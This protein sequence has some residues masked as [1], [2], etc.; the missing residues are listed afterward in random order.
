MKSL[1]HF[2]LSVT[3]AVIVFAGCKKE[4]APPA[5]DAPAAPPP[6]V[7]VAPGQADAPPPPPI[8][9]TPG[10]NAAA[11]TVEAPAE[12]KPFAE[13]LP[14]AATLSDMEKLNWAAEAFMGE[15]TAPP[16][17]NV[18]QLVRA[19]YFRVAPA[20]PPGKKFLFTS[21][22]VKLVDEGAK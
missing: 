3:A 1:L 20:P 7:A 5:A 18:Q 19:G 21:E 9:G 16:L 8:P 12:A 13:Q 2:S 6:P 11:P 15:A 17:T 4:E 22:G 14:N 10:A